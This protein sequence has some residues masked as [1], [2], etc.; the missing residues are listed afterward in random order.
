MD[1]GSPPRRS[2]NFGRSRGRSAVDSRRDPGHRRHRHRVARAGSARHRSRHRRSPRRPRRGQ[3]LH[4][5]RCAR[6]TGL[7]PHRPTCPH[8]ARVAA[9]RSST[10]VDLMTQVSIDIREAG[11]RHVV[12]AIAGEIDLATA[13]LLEGALRWYTECDVIVDLSAV[14]LLDASGLTALIRTQQAVAAD[15]SHPPNDR[16]ARRCAR[17]DEGHRPRGHVPWSHR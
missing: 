1:R 8:C 12:V 4:M 11:E 13:P 9:R 10:S 17:R 5:T 3:R 6:R 7:A 15:G 2:L 14:R 16:R